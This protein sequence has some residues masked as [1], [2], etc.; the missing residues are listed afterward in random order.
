MLFTAFGA[1]EV[2]KTKLSEPL[3]KAQTRPGTAELA[4][5]VPEFTRAAAWLD[6]ERLLDIP[7]YRELFRE[8][9]P[10][11]KEEK[12]TREELAHSYLF[13]ATEDLFVY[14]A[15]IGKGKGSL[16]KL[17]T[18]FRTSPYVV[19][20]SLVRPDTLLVIW[21]NIP[22]PALKL[23][24]KTALLKELNDKELISS[25]GNIPL[26]KL[27]GKA[28]EKLL[29]EFPE[30]SHLS[31][32]QLTVK[33]TDLKTSILFIFDNDKS[34]RKGFTFLNWGLTL[35]L[36][37]K[38]AVFR[39]IQQHIEKNLLRLT[40]FDPPLGKI[41]QKLTS[42]GQKKSLSAVS[43]M[44]RLLLALELY[45]ADHAGR[46]PDS[47]AQL[48][49]VFLP[50]LPFLTLSGKNSPYLFQAP[51]NAASPVLWENPALLPPAKK[52]LNVIFADGT[53]AKRPVTLPLFSA[54]KTTPP[55]R[56]PR[57]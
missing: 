48:Q 47:L 36:L 12:F 8:I 56:E 41:A 6:G 19:K 46:Y 53:A 49:G 2:D 17:H 52:Q 14:G 57:P 10:G 20:L 31:Q 27:S 38:T 42:A 26:S 23:K 35:V 32:I 43:Q 9:I 11:A 37:H 15:V 45:A 25:A 3:R 21:G 24:G 28:P 5:F 13:F 18:F 4:P 51:S 39:R 30:L 54:V 29:K 16:S 44:R 33:R 40:L 22:T 50:A 7:Q 1:S 34:P 55:K